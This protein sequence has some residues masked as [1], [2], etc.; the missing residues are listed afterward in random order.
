MAMEEG[1]EKKVEKKKT[2]GYIGHGGYYGLNFA[3][4]VILLLL[5]MVAKPCCWCNCYR[6]GSSS[7]SGGEIVIIRQRWC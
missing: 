2:K 1:E 6:F 5:L 7:S 3:V 4:Y